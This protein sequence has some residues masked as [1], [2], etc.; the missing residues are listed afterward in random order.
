MTKK[1]KKMEAEQ[2][3][4]MISNASGHPV[5][6]CASLI[7]FIEE[8]EDPVELFQTVLEY[9]DAIGNSE[10]DSP[11]IISLEELKKRIINHFSYIVTTVRLLAQ[12]NLPEKEFYTQLYEII[13][14][15]NKYGILGQ[16]RVDK[17]I[18]LEMMAN[19]IKE[20]P[21]YMLDISED[22][23]DSDFQDTVHKLFPVLQKTAHIFHRNLDTNSIQGRLLVQQFQELEN[24]K[25]RTVF[26]TVL[27]NIIRSKYETDDEED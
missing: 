5:D 16:A 24:E 4:E 10:D 18:H 9:P 20:L 3:K 15:D 1:N 6:V 13:M 17:A 27:I 26:M 23:T 7:D 11:Q 25:E 14:N 22:I 12:K 19:H 8:S 21:Y 2:L